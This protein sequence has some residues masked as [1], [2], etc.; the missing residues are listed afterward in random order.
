MLTES[1]PLTK[2]LPAKE[3]KKFASDRGLVT[4]GDLMA[5]WPRRYRSRESDLG[6]LT[7]G[8]F[9]VAVA[10][11]KTAQ[12]RRMKNRR[13][14]MLEAV[15]TDGTH[16][17]GVTFFSAWGHES[18]L[19]PGARGIFAGTVSEFNRK[20][21]LA[22]PGYTL[23]DDFDK[24]ERKDLIPIYLSVGNLHTWT[25]TE[26]VRTVLD[27]VDDAPDVIP[28]EVRGRRKLL[29]RIDALRGIHTP[30]SWPE[31]EAARHRLR[32]E[33]AFLLQLVLARRRAE[34]ARDALAKA[35]SEAE[36]KFKD[37]P[38]AV[39][40]AEKLIARVAA[41]AKISAETDVAFKADERCSALLRAPSRDSMLSYVAD[42]PEVG[43][44]L[45]ALIAA[46]ES[47]KS[48]E[49]GVGLQNWT[50]THVG[51][52]SRFLSV[53]SVMGDRLVPR[54]N[55]GTLCYD[56]LPS[57]LRTAMSPKTFM[58]A[59]RGSTC[60]SLAEGTVI[61]NLRDSAIKSLASYLAREHDAP[62]K[63]HLAALAPA[64]GAVKADRPLASGGSAAQALVDAYM[65]EIYDS[66]GFRADVETVQ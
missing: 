4:V 13:G 48:A 14:S 39:L 54:G 1:T 60:V 51:L 49:L 29:S 62:T 63:A 52:E 40:N 9:V 2:L 35:V 12:T 3:A 41:Y 28:E 25:V 59:G 43:D 46:Y 53:L 8:E 16:D 18:K 22:H 34:T 21:Q 66:F 38:Y 50:T 32:Y 31:V 45:A 10:E 57:G 44:R 5:F 19:R 6:G 23:L 36:T 58:V 64:V 42:H 30:N 17:L 7:P 65:Y 61:A 33:E 37:K 47:R 20:P 55:G 15:I 11:V 26:C 24:G 27:M 56:D